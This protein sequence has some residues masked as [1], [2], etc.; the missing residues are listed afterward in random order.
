MSSKGLPDPSFHRCKRS[1]ASSERSDW[2]P[3]SLMSKGL[4]CGFPIGTDVSKTFTILR[5]RMKRDW[6]IREAG[7]KGVKDALE[8][9][10]RKELTTNNQPGAV[11]PSSRRNFLRKSCLAAR[12][13]SSASCASRRA[14]ARNRSA[15]SMFAFAQAIS[16]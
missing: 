2:W 11:W 5:D 16:S 14:S 6:L 1:S 10:N 3:C 13:S 4:P 7:Q 8:P 15:F 12:S 9:L